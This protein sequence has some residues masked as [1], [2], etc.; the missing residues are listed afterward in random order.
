LTLIKYCFTFGSYSYEKV[1]ILFYTKQYLLSMTQE[2][3]S[4]LK[5]KL[6]SK[7]L[8]TLQKR[9]NQK[10]IRKYSLSAISQVLSGTYNNYEIIDAAIKLAE[11]YKEEL[12]LR[13]E[14]IQSL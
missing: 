13:A 1:I 4:K 3:L 7:Y 9:L 14:K 10:R 5:S 8:V 11:E 12:R 6:P 2:E